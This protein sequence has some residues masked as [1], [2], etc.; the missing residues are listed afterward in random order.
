VADEQDYVVTEAAHGRAALV[1]LHAGTTPTVMLFDQYMPVM[2]GQEL[3]RRILA[4]ASLS[5]HC[6]LVCVTASEVRLSPDLSALLEAHDIS[7]L[8]KPVDIGGLLAAVATA[9]D[10]LPV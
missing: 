6:S 8:A 4:D 7:V 9:V 10:K 5:A 2:V 1:I 3:L